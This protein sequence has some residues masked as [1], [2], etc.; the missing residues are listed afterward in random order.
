[1]RRQQGRFLTRYDKVQQAEPT[2]AVENR[3]G[4]LYAVLFNAVQGQFSLDLEFVYRSL[5][6]AGVPSSNISA[7]EGDGRTTNRFVDKPATMRSLDD[8]VDSIRK[9]ASPNDRLLVYVANH[10][11]LENGQCGVLAYDGVIWEKEF[12]QLM[13]DLPVN[14]GLFYFAQCFSGGFS[15]R[16]GYGRNICMSNA[17]RT[18]FGYKSSQSVYLG[19]SQYRYNSS[20]GRVAA[21]FTHFLFPNILNPAKSV[22][23][24]F[25]EA[26]YEDTSIKRRIGIGRR[27]GDH[28]I[29]S[30]VSGIWLERETPQLRWQNADPSQLHLGYGLSST[31]PSRE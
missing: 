11:V 22:E 24:A 15:E 9:K 5:I 2:A 7:L 20:R 28:H 21:F 17:N 14:F 30:E 19:N 25:D 29:W 6:S 4:Y 3:E 23:E 12:E 1:M 13:Q 8:V 31:A 26:V 16:M 18:G 10:G 27:H